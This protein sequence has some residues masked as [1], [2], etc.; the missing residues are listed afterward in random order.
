[1][2]QN[3]NITGNIAKWAAE[4]AEFELDFLPHHAIKSLV[5]ADFVAD[6]TPLPCNPWGSGDSEPEAKAPVFTEPHWMLFFDSSSRK[7]GARAGI[8]L[9]TPDGE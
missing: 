5:L 9:L 3:P 2:L 1:M 6:W 7:H 8:L 4:L